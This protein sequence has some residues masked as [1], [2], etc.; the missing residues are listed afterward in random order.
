MGL[1]QKHRLKHRQDFQKVYKQGG[2]YSS[3]HLTIRTLFEPCEENSIVCQGTC[4]GISVSSK[5]SKR[6]VRRNRIKRLIRSSI[7]ELLPQVS[8][9]W[10]VVIVVRPG[11]LEC[12]YEHFLRELKQLLIKAEIINGHQREY[13]L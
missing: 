6:A 3:P 2:R 5:I 12:K 9:G 1:P 4:F 10:K 11:S 8:P 13:I 7:R